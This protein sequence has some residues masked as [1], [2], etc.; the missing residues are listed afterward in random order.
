MRIRKVNRVLR[1][2]PK[3][4]REKGTNTSYPWSFKRKAQ[5]RDR[6]GFQ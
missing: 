3:R 1:V 6:Y 4:L 2:H 5:K